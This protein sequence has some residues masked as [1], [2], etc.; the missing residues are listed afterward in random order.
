[1]D[2]KLFWT[3]VIPKYYL[4]PPGLRF[5]PAGIQPIYSDR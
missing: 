5:D 1:M 2:L 3:A 4:I